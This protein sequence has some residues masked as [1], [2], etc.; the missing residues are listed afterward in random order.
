MFT[1]NSVDTFTTRVLAGL[2]L[3]VTVVL[4]SLTHAVANMQAFV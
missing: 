1:C 3:A 2:V 4:G